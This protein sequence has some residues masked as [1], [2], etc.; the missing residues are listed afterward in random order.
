MNH[1]IHSADRATHLK[2]V[3]VAGMAV[4]VVCGL[5]LDLSAYTQ[6]VPTERTAVLNLGKPMSMSSSTAIVAR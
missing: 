1:S 2:V 5:T 3:V 4:A 6:S